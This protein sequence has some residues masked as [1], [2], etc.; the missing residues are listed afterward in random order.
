M[1]LG[2]GKG[3]DDAQRVVAM[4]D[5]VGV[6]EIGA[7][8]RKAK[9]GSRVTY[10]RVLSLENG[11]V[12]ADL[13]VRAQ[14][15]EAGEF[16]ITGTPSSAVEALAW[17]KVAK[18]AHAGNAVLTGF[19]LVDLLNVSGGDHMVLAELAQTLRA[20]GLE[21][22]GGIGVRVLS[23]LQLRAAFDFT[24]Y[25]LTFITQPTDTYVAAGA[26]DTYLGGKASVRLT[27]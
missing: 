15:I 4:A 25:G 11:D 21:G 16:R 1:T 27:F 13:K 19:S 2:D 8:A 18:A 7:A 26:A 12:G 6:G 10:G 5:L 20:F 9:H 22:G 23:F 17:T 24:R 14:E 3:R